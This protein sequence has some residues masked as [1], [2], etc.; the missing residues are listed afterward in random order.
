MKKSRSRLTAERYWSKQLNRPNINNFTKSR[1]SDIYRKYF[2]IRK[3][4]DC[5]EIGAYPG[6]ELGYLA[7][8]YKYD[9][10][11]LDYVDDVGFIKEHLR[12]GGI[13]NCSIIK[14]DFLKWKTTKRYDMV[15]S[16]G[17]VEHFS[18][19]NFVLKKQA[20]LVKNGG[21]LLL[22]VPNLEYFQLW[23]RRLFYKKEYMEYILKIHNRKI[24]NLEAIRKILKF[25]LGMEEID[26]SY[27][28]YGY[29]WF[30]CDEN[31]KPEMRKYFKLLKI[32]TDIISLLRLSNKY[33][34]PEIVYIAKKI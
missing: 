13:T 9:V 27:R 18:D 31:V 32:I 10:T 21:M 5:L 7:K 2:K 22:I 26:A 17:F 23:T 24:M 16:F 19:P 29:N 3:G 15:C 14:A 6:S 12:R 1:Y 33:I 11:A 30:K 25:D 8:N 4:L 34:S 28:G 20:G